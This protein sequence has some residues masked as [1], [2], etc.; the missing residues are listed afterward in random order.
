M[1]AVVQGTLSRVNAFSYSLPRDQFATHLYFEAFTIRDGS[2]SC[3][4]LLM[5]I[6]LGVIHVSAIYFTFHTHCKG[7]ITANS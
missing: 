4:A 5:V 7:T 3:A 1:I 2:E 6:S